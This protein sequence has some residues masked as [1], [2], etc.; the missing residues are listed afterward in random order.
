VNRM[1]APAPAP[2]VTKECPLCTTAI[3][4]KARRCPACTADLHAA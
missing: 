3:P 4:V 2:A 1:R